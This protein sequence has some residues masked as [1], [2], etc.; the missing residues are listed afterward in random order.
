MSEER[1]LENPAF[2]RNVVVGLATVIT[3]ILSSFILAEWTMWPRIALSVA[4]MVLVAFAVEFAF[5]KS[6]G[7]PMRPFLR[8]LY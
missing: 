5:A 6:G 3:A 2:R 1:T 8:R 4:A 7:V